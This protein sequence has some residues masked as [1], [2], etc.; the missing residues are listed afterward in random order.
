MLLLSS[1]GKDENLT[2]ET[3]RHAYTNCSECPVISIEIPRAIEKRKICE[4]VNNAL[5]EEVISLL[6]YEEDEVIVDIPGALSSFSRG[7]K[8]LTNKFPDEAIPWEARIKGEITYESKDLLTIGLSSY[9][10]TGGAHGYGSTRFLNFDKRSGEEL[11]STMLF[12]NRE[13]F[14]RFAETKFRMQED[15]P[16]EEPINS[17]GFMFEQDIYYLPENI[18]FTQEG[19][20]LLYNPYE[21]ASYADGTI[22][23]ILPYSEVKK[24]LALGI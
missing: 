16:Q 20:K 5:K 12:K 23:L 24:Y 8:D 13:K 19:L 1:C 7:F 9:I 17:T 15:I 4:T 21:V 6:S 2:F 22:E 3:E 11:E 10:F 18:G 14:E